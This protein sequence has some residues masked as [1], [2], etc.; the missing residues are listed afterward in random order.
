VSY[1]KHDAIVVTHWER[2]DVERARDRA[3]QLNLPVSDIAISPRNGYVSFLIA[4]DGSYEKW[5][6]SDHADK[7]RVEWRAWVAEH[8]P[9][10]RWVH[11]SYDERHIAQ[12]VA[13][14]HETKDG[15]P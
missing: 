8:L 2:F 6:P 10:L 11:V 5:E 4:P 15:E 14:D 12:I 13:Q 7:A 9:Q 1:T 3:F